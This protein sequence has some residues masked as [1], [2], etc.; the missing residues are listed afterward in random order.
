MINSREK[1]HE[2]GEGPG[3]FSDAGN[4]VGNIFVKEGMKKPIAELA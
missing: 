1:R 3:G 4:G 2:A